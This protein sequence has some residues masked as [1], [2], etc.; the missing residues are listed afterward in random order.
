[1]DAIFNMPH[2]QP[3]ADELPGIPSDLQVR[4]CPWFTS[5]FSSLLAFPMSTHASHRDVCQSLM[6][7]A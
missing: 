1:M 3:H 6:H 5:C 7:V 2:V 4:L